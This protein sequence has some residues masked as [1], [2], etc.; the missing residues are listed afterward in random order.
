[1]QSVALCKEWDL[2]GMEIVAIDGSKFRACNSKKNN[3]NEKKLDIK[4]KYLEEKIQ[5]Y[6][7]EIDDNDNKEKDI[8][9]PSEEVVKKVNELKEHKRTYEEYKVKI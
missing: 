8:K 6:M 9:T 7:T 4:I 5:K 1:M 3:F 2:Y